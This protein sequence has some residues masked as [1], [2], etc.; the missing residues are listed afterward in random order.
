M[1]YGRL[2]VAAAVVSFTSY[3][4]LEIFQAQGWTMPDLLAASLVALMVLTGSMAFLVV[5]YECWHVTGPVR[6]AW[7]WRWPLYRQNAPS[8]HQWI[9]DIARND[10]TSPANH[11]IVL[12]RTIVTMDLRSEIPRPWI[13][14]GLELYNGG[15]HSILIGPM[16]GHVTY[17]GI[18]ELRDA[19]EI[20]GGESR[21]PRGH[22]HVHRL[23]Q[24]LPP[25]VAAAIYE[26]IRATRKVCSLGLSSVHL[27]VKSE[28]EN[29]RTVQMPLGGDDT[30][31]APN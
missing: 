7:G 27:T 24:Y 28:A 13:E 21:K 10:A 19:P 25:E 12:S 23:K 20:D 14:L 11:L 31:L 30:F 9:L 3:I 22:R 1:G 6:S 5:A 26:E 18:G 2:G 15:V 29:G 17:D 4:T 16:K 8:P